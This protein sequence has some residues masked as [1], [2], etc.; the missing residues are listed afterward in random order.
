[1][2]QEGERGA[3]RNDGHDAVDVMGLIQIAHEDNHRINHEIRHRLRVR[4]QDDR[5]V[6]LEIPE[7]TFINQ[8]VH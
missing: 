3:S 5:F 2:L 6:D 8:D 4:L 1:L 7:V